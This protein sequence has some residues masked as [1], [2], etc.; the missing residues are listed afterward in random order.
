M[1]KSADTKESKSPLA[2]SSTSQLPRTAVN[3]NKRVCLQRSVD[4][5]LLPLLLS[6]Q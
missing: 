4:D 2:L 1:G 3:P 6:T 5:V